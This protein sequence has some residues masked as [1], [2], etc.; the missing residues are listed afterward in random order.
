MHAL[1]RELRRGRHEADDQA[2]NNA[3]DTE[4]ELSYRD[5]FHCFSSY[6]ALFSANI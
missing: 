6:F 2:E 1:D 4:H 3:Q 5:L